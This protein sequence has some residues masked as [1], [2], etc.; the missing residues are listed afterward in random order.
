MRITTGKPSMALNSP[1]KSERC[2]GSSFSSAL[3][4]DLLVARQNHGLHVRHAILGEEHVLGAAQADAL[5]AEAAGRLGVARDIGVGADTERAAEFVRLTHERG[6]DT[7]RSGRRRWCWPGRGILRR[8]NRRATA[9][10]LPL[11]RA[12]LPLTFTD[13]SLLVLADFDRARAGHAG[14]AHAASDHR[15]VAGHAAARSQNALGDFH[16]VNIVRLRF[17]ANQNHRARF[18]DLTTASSAVNTITPTAAP[19]DAGSPVAICSRLFA[20]AGSSTGCSS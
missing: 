8:S 1:A 3:R 16:A 4:R 12:F 18:R 17:G 10:R 2:I 6:E 11:A 13:S 19:G 5:G 9:S 15:R 7:P 14:N 20:L